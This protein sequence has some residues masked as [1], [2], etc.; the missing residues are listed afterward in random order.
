M[1]CCNERKKDDHLYGSVSQLPL[2]SKKHRGLG[3]VPPYAASK[4]SSPIMVNECSECEKKNGAGH[5]APKDVVK[6]I[7]NIVGS[8][9]CFLLR[10][11]NGIRK[12]S[13]K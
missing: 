1:I 6:Y 10:S 9:I 8:K 5:T 13:G 11:W 2:Q 3:V 12:R 7:S 4:Q